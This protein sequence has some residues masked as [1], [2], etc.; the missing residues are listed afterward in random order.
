MSQYSSNKSKNIKILSK[1][2]KTETKN[3]TVNKE[4]KNL[5]DILKPIVHD[6]SKLCKKHNHSSSQRIEEKNDDS[7]IKLI[8]E[9]PKS[10]RIDNFIKSNVDKKFLCLLCENLLKDPMECY[11]C[12]NLFC[13]ECIKKFLK[14]E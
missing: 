14:I 8:F 5:Y 12:L 2:F 3:R 1:S 7:C 6:Y 4:N 11:K 13:T 10:K 9:E